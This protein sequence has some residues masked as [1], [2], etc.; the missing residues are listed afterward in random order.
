M[1]LELRR[2]DSV[3]H[4]GQ[5]G[6]LQAGGIGIDQEKESVFR[7]NLRGKAQEGEDAFFYF[8]DLAFRPRP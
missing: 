3:K 2:D 4:I 7:Q 5:Y 6:R 1:A 8:P